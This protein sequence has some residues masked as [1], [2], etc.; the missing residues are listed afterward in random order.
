M[1][2]S[3]CTTSCARERRLELETAALSKYQGAVIQYICRDLKVHTT[4]IP[5]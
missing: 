4:I 5:S 2:L 3:H 1:L